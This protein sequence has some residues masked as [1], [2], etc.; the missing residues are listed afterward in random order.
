MKD[1]LKSLSVTGTGT[2][3][4]VGAVSFDTPTDPHTQLGGRGVQI[5][6]RATRCA[7]C[8][9]GCGAAPSESTAVTPGIGA[10]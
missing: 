9:T 2:E 1:V 10:R 3:L 4:A 5:R 6:S 8:S 7:D